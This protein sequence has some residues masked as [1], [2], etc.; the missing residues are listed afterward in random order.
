MCKSCIAEWTKFAVR[1][2]LSFIPLMKDISVRSS[3]FFVFHPAYEHLPYPQK[4]TGR[5]LL[6]SVRPGL[7]PWQGDYKGAAFSF[8]AFHSDLA[9][10]RFN[11]MLNDCKTEPG[12][13]GLP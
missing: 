8:L 13:A 6:N 5:A 11:K 7:R 2:L 4:A 3:C 9:M 1:P 12:A 10:V